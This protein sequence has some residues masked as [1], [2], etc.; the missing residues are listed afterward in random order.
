[1]AAELQAAKAQAIADE[2]AEAARAEPH[3]E[4]AAVLRDRALLHARLAES[5]MAF[6][7]QARGREDAG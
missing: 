6:A 3:P 4:L 7:R 2:Y 5:F 1:M